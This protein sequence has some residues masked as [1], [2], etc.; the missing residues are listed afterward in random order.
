MFEVQSVAA[1][2]AA[3]KGSAAKTSAKPMVIEKLAASPSP[4]PEVALVAFLGMTKEELWQKAWEVAWKKADILGEAGNEAQVKASAQKLWKGWLQEQSKALKQKPAAP[5]MA[6]KAKTLASAKDAAVPA[7]ATNATTTSSTGKLPSSTPT[8]KVEHY[9]GSSSST[10]LTSVQASPAGTAAAAGGSTV[11]GQEWRKAQER[12]WRGTAEA[13]WHRAKAESEKRMAS[14][15]GVVVG[16]EYSSSS[17]RDLC[18]ILKARC[19]ADQPLPFER[20]LA[21]CPNKTM[22]KQL[23][24]AMAKE[25]QEFRQNVE[26]SE[27]CVR[28]VNSRCADWLPV[29]SST[30]PR[31]FK[32]NGC[33]PESMLSKARL[34][35]EE[36]MKPLGQAAEDPLT[37][38]LTQ[39]GRL[40]ADSPIHFTELI[41]RCPPGTTVVELVRVMAKKRDLFRQDSTGKMFCV[42]PRVKCKDWGAVNPYADPTAVKAA[43]GPSSMMGCGAG[44]SGIVV[45][46]PMVSGEDGGR[47]D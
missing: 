6:A 34:I 16:G 28:P 24:Q 46:G 44:G 22:V 26:G 47:E 1:A 27:F 18:A 3:S 40:P 29:N 10:S 13:D 45:G 39:P 23:I 8:S 14:F 2:A 17:G 15:G 43:P 21:V 25:P 32:E 7:R 19:P 41:S 33:L 9:C 11:P 42:R 35:F 30:V 4:V 37:I 5:S 20:L 12:N 31:G 38:F 36:K